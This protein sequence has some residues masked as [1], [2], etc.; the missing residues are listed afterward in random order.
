MNIVDSLKKLIVALNGANSPESVPAKNVDEAIDYLSLR[1]PRQYPSWQDLLS[2]LDEF[3]I[4]YLYT[5]YDGKLYWDYDCTEKVYSDELDGGNG[6]ALLGRCVLFY[7]I[8]N[9]TYKPYRPFTIEERG[10]LNALAYWK[11]PDTETGGYYTAYAVS[12]DPSEET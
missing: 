4:Q 7:K 11:G 3:R 8:N 1:V 12:W 6:I 9:R 2:I 10:N 5:Q